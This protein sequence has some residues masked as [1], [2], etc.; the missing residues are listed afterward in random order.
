MAKSPRLNVLIALTDLL[1]TITPANGYDHDLSTGVRR[2]IAVF[3]DEAPATLLSILEAPR[4]DPGREIG[5][6]DRGRNERWTL[7]LQGWCPDDS[8]NPTDPVYE[9]AEDV[10]RCL[11]QITAETAHGRPVVPDVYLLGNLITDFSMQPP[12]VRPPTEGVSPKAFFYIQVQIG[13]ATRTA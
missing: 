9:M 6:L 1:K 13:L 11:R 7:L 2:G 12:V 4:P 8:E 10:E 5:D 3:G